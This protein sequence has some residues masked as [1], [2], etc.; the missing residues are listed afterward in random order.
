MT[1]NNAKNSK[2][3]RYSLP[4]S[5]SA[6]SCDITDISSVLCS[7]AASSIESHLLNMLCLELSDRITTGVRWAGSCE[8]FT[9]SPSSLRSLEFDRPWIYK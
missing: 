1:C 4:P 5:D 9:Q 6:L 3:S 8:G 7:I 2:Q